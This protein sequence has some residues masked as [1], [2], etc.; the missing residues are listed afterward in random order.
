MFVTSRPPRP[1]PLD[2]T[3][4][5]IGWVLIGWGLVLGVITLHAAAVTTGQRIAARRTE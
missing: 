3:Y 2:L 4:L 5:N 1:N